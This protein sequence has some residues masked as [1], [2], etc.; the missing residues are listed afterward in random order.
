MLFA[1]SHFVS[2]SSA[3]AA[4]AVASDLLRGLDAEL[5]QAL[6]HDLEHPG[7]VEVGRGRGD[8]LVAHRMGGLRVLAAR[9]R[10]DADAVR[11]SLVAELVE[12]LVRRRAVVL[13]RPEVRV[14]ERRDV[15]DEALDLRRVAAEDDLD[16]LVAVDAHRE[17]LLHARVE[18]LAVLELPRVRV[19]R[20]VRDLAARPLVHLHAL[21]LLDRVHG[22]EG[23]LVD[24]VEVAPPQVG[25]HRVGVRVVRQRDRVGVRLR[26]VEVR[27][28]DERR[29]CPS[30]RTA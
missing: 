5:R 3:Y 17:R 22:V 10:R 29:S 14:L 25:D 19:P 11:A 27:V 12:R 4:V 8:D 28:R 30:S 18:E 16:H 7:A 13:R 23:H 20:D 1:A 2:V 24:P 21:A 9:R 6:L 15:P 26:P